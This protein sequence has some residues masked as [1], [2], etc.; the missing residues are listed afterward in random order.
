MRSRL[1]KFEPYQLAALSAEW[2]KRIF[3]QEQ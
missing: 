3:E 1:K 2:E